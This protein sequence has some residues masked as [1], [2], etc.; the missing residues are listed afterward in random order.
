MGTSR[1]AERHRAKKREDVDDTQTEQP[2]R[3]HSCRYLFQNLTAKWGAIT[4][5]TSDE[6]CSGEQHTMSTIGQARRWMP[7][8]TVKESQLTPPCKSSRC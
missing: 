8:R 3:Y 4:C 6:L 7:S 1:Q 2:E 5:K